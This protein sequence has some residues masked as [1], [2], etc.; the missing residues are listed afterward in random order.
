MNIKASAECTYEEFVSKINNALIAYYKDT[1]NVKV[2]HVMKNNGKEL[3]GVNV[4]LENQVISPTVYLEEYYREY[5]AGETLSDIVSLL[6]K[7]IESECP[8]GDFDTE[9]YCKYENAK[10]RIVFKLINREKN[11]TL[12]AD[13]PY[14]EY[15]DLAIVFVYLVDTSKGNEASI[16]VKNSHLKMWGVDC[17]CLYDDA[18]KNSPILLE[19]M[20]EDLQ[21]IMR[22]ILFDKFRNKYEAENYEDSFI[23]EMVDEIMGNGVC[24]RP[25]N[26]YVLTNKIGLFG[27]GAILY[28]NVLE[29]FSKKVDS[30]LIILPSSIH[31]VIIVPL[32][33]LST[34]DNLRQMVMEINSTQVADEEVLSDS[35][36]IYRND[37]NC[38]ELL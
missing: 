19:Y 16:L 4:K 21:D 34:T 27:A 7:V 30:D 31:E 11:K 5:I 26:M 3:I 18:V 1:A 22:K 23:F 6:I 24:T 17:H 8:L 13:S 37:N 29:E 20:L 15:L 12:L 2:C 9:Q 33:E 36:Y 28:S 32:N 10:E 14:I 25:V 35:V 38:I